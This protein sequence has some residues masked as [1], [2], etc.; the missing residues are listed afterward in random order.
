MLAL[1]CGL[2]AAVMLDYFH[3]QKSSGLADVAALLT[4]CADAVGDADVL[5]ARLGD[6]FWLLR[7]SL[8]R[9]QRDAHEP[10]VFVQLD[11]SSAPQRADERT[12]TAAAAACG[13]VSRPLRY[14][15]ALT[16]AFSD[17]FVDMLL[18]AAAQAGG[19]A[20]DVTAVYEACTVVPPTLHGVLL[21][22][23]CVYLFAADSGCVASAP[24]LMQPV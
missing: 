13:E 10:P 8:L 14:G 7:P 3:A 24:R 22:Y 9:A 17:N 18:A 21:D 2:K 1:L 15:W 20:V 5:A 12:A 23:P 6:C 16:R 19:A 4:A 11:S